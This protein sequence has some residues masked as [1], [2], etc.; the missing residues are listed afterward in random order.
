[1]LGVFPRLSA[2]FTVI[3]LV[4]CI[5]GPIYIW[6]L[7]NHSDHFQDLSSVGGDFL[8]FYDSAKLAVMGK[9]EA[10]MNYA[11]ASPVYD[12][13]RNYYSWVFPPSFLAILLPFSTF[14]FLNGYLL[15]FGLSLVVF[16]ASC[17]GYLHPLRRSIFLLFAPATLVVLFFGQ[18]GLLVAAILCGGLRLID[19][20]PALGGLLLGFMFIKPELA[21]L[22]PFALIAQ[23]NIIGFCTML[24]SAGLTVVGSVLL[25]GAP[26]WL[27]YLDTGP[28]ALFSL[29][30]SADSVSLQLMPSIYGAMRLLGFSGSL[31][32]VVMG[33][34]F[35]AALSITF[36]LFL[37]PREHSS[38][39]LAFGL[40][41]LLA[42]PLVFL[43]DLAIV[44]PL[45]FIFACKSKVFDNV[46]G[47]S[48][49]GA[50]LLMGV[51]LLP[52]VG[53]G[54][55]A[56]GFPIGPFVLI[57]AL[58]YLLYDLMVQKRA[59]RAAMA[60]ARSENLHIPDAASSQR[61]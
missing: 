12:S 46:L 50:A 40:C 22:I 41:C 26:A 45:M 6:A 13:G 60:E 34:S 48:Y 4:T 51:Y 32:L 61:S 7:W 17:S 8:Y 49:T 5:G 44:V 29:L 30:T 59:A 37:T 21:L 52:L 28:Q 57:S 14:S 16:L 19:N 36:W 53:F 54:L 10:L 56:H 18:S 39:N 23:G 9:A 33:V 11:G 15:W 42:S 25:F 58:A 27:N 47:S 20:R 2:Y 24:T 3:L 35:L 1:M 31:A 43:W 55:A 38:R